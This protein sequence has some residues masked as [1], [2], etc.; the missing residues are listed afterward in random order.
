M[1]PFK[2]IK[3]ASPILSVICNSRSLEVFKK[4]QLTI[5]LI[6]G[7][8]QI[9]CNPHTHDLLIGVQ[10]NNIKLMMIINIFY[11][12]TFELIWINYLQF[13]L[14]NKYFHYNLGHFLNSWEDNAFYKVK[15][16]IITKGQSKN[17]YGT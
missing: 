12:L 1:W 14:P 3:A 7:D 2:N 6:H 4:C 10:Q 5:P 17:F 8:L 11:F 13:M 15:I 9:I 16:Q